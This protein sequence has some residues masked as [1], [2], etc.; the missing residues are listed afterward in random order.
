MHIA[1]TYG[2]DRI[3]IV[4]VGD[5]K[6]MEFPIEFF[7]DYA[8]TPSRWNQDNLHQFTVDWAKREFGP[9]HAEEIA[10]CVEGYTRLN[11]GRKPELLDPTTFSITN[12]NEADRVAAEWN[13]LIQRTDALAKEL[14]A[15]EQASFSN[16]SNTPWMPAAMLRSCTSLRA[17]MPSA[18]V[19]VIGRPTNTSL[20]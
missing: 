8:R 14:P 12:Y 20:R 4:N 9:D 5:L 11:S 10:S 2:A 1:L 16:W 19:W 15:D 3:W 7:L 13:G 18:P 6:P 17:T